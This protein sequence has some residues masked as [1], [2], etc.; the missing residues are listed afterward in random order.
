MRRQSLSK[1]TK[2]MCDE[3]TPD[4]HRVTFK[5]VPWVTDAYAVSGMVIVYSVT[6]AKNNDKI[7]FSADVDWDTQN[8]RLRIAFPTELN[9]RHMYEIPYGMI[10]RKP[11]EPRILYDDGSSNWAS[12]AGDYPAINWAGIEDEKAGIALFNKGTPSY[13]INTDKFNKQNIY[14]SVLRSPSVGT[15]LHSPLEYS[16]TDYDGMRDAGIHHF[17]YALKT[18]DSGFEENSVVADGIGYNTHIITFNGIATLKQMPEV[19]TDNARISSIAPA[20]D[21]EGLIMRIAEFRG[22][23]SELKIKAPDYVKSVSET[24]LKEDFVESADICDGVINSEIKP[25]EIKTF[26]LEI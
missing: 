13:Q 6:L 18:Y 22:C 26:Y 4:Y 23:A 14:L 9:G 1:Y 25:F 2:I 5:I 3:K 16:M 24:D 7:L 11:Y 10:E 12:A 8:Y 21:K 19:L 15:Y 17:E 20:Q